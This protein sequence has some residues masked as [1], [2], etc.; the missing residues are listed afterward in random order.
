MNRATAEIIAKEWG[1]E[2]WDSGGGCCFVQLPKSNGHVVLMSCDVVMEFESA[3]ACVLFREH[4]E[5]SAC[6]VQPLKIMDLS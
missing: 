3:E 1:G 2:V 4:E 5:Q 6:P